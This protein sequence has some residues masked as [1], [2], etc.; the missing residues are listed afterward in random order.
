MMNII[1]KPRLGVSQTIEHFYQSVFRISDSYYQTVDSKPAN[2]AQ[3]F[4]TISHTKI[5]NTVVEAQFENFSNHAIKC[6]FQTRHIVHI[7]RIP[8]TTAVDITTVRTNQINLNIFTTA[9]KLP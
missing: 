8:K 5:T 1:P 2:F 4:Y 6:Y 9:R 7:K 3:S